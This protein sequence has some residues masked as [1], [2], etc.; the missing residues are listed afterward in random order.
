MEFG[1]SNKFKKSA[2]KIGKSNLKYKLKIND[3]I[4][5]FQKKLFNSKYYRKKLKNYKNCHSLT[6]TGD[7]RIVIEIL[8]KDNKCYFLNIGTHSDLEIS[9][10]KRNKF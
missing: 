6:V 2:K 10:E 1:Y 9:S 7:I 3:C 8:I 4:K 5:D